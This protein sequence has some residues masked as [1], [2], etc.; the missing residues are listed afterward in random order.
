MK[1]TSSLVKIGAAV[2]LAMGL[3]ACDNERPTDPQTPDV[4][5]E[6]Q[7]QGDVDLYGTE[8]Q[9]GTQQG[10]PGLNDPAATPPATTTTPGMGSGANQTQQPGQGDVD[11]YGDDPNQANQGQNVP[12]GSPYAPETEQ[13]EET[14]TTPQGN[15][16]QLPARP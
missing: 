6:T 4:Q 11:L 5:N 10:Q 7:G 1:P 3:A 2:V 13:R 9:Q 16:Q 8:P 12:T 14:E 15:Q